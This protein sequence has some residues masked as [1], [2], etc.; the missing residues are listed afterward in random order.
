MFQ[1]SLPAF[2]TQRSLRRDWDGGS[3]Q[4]GL[5]LC[6]VFLVCLVF[7]Y[8]VLY[9]DIFRRIMPN[10]AVTFVPNAY[11]G[12]KLNTYI[13]TYCRFLNTVEPVDVPADKGFSGNTA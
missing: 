7:F 6:L 4:C 3:A 9:T 1:T 8:S 11:G 2:P 12:C 13:T 10:S 5:E